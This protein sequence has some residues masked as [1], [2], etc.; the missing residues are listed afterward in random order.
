VIDVLGLLLYGSRARGDHRPDSDVDLLAVTV[1]RRAPTATIG[2]W[3]LSTYPQPEVVRRAQLGD[4]FVLHLVAEGAVLFDRVGVFELMRGAFIFRDQYDREVTL[5]SDVG[6]FLVRHGHDLEPHRL[7][8]QMAW[9]T[10]T[11]LV[12]RAASDRRAVFSAEALATFAG[13]PEVVTII[14]HRSETTTAPDVRDR[15]VGVLERFGAPPRSPSRT[16]AEQRREFET[17]RNVVG[18]RMAGAVMARRRPATAAE[19]GGTRGDDR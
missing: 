3:R 19:I 12:A 5:A 2:G 11:I 6:W 15:F 7:N 8:E 18:V 10:R 9:C 1:D 17:D 14:E 13:C 4:L 16:V